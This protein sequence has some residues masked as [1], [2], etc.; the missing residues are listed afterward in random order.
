MSFFH[1][2][3]ISW[4]K[5]WALVSPLI[6]SIFFFFNTIFHRWISSSCSNSSTNFGKQNYNYLKKTVELQTECF[7]VDSLYERENEWE[8]SM[9]IFSV[10]PLIFFQFE[11]K[12]KLIKKLRT[13]CIN[14]VMLNE[15]ISKR[16]NWI[17]DRLLC[18]NKWARKLLLINNCILCRRKRKSFIQFFRCW[19]YIFCCVVSPYVDDI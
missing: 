11:M 9:N 14:C 3:D 7:M 8:K 19:C 1:A 2:A 4:F 16:R 6:F 12:S 15:S 13:I 18:A 5:L 17:D 10:F